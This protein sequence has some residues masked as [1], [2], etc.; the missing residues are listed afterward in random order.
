MPCPNHN[1]FRYPERV[2]VERHAMAIQLTVVRVR[3]SHGNFLFLVELVG[4]QPATPHCRYMVSKSLSAKTKT[5]RVIRGISVEYA[6]EGR[7]IEH[8]P[9]QNT[10]K[11]G[12]TGFGD[13]PAPALLWWGPA[14]LCDAG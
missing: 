1:Q 5:G 6:V 13:K 11:M 12:L 10:R 8:N 7:R 14:V 4:T 2:A 3:S 9:A